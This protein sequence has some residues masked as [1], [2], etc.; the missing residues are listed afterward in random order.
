VTIPKIIH[1]IWIGGEVPQSVAQLMATWPRRHPNWEYRLWTDDNLPDLKNS[2][3]FDKAP[4][5]A[6]KADLLRYEI[7]LAEGGLY[8]DADFECHRP[9]D[10]LMDRV[11]DLLLVSEF[12]TV[13][14]GFIGCAPADPFLV[15]CVTEVRTRMLATSPRDWQERPY[16]ITGPALVDELFVKMDVAVERPES[17]LP[18]DYFFVPRTR[19]PELL[20]LAQRKRYATHAAL[21]T[22]RRRTLNQRLREL[23]PRTR[24][25]RFR[26][27]THP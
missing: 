16:L 19:V 4:S 15:Q 7:L 12:G 6:M 20:K 25:R 1:Q 21:A 13:C 17:L 5:F 9:L 24:W 8:I 2:D 26:D 23:K 18:G 14:N 3:L 10:R 11:N 22:W 27:L